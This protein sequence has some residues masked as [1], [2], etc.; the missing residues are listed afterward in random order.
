M[1]MKHFLEGIPLAEFIKTLTVQILQDLDI[2]VTAQ[3]FDM[4][5]NTFIVRSV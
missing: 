3:Q 5:H 2:S 1:L 4:I